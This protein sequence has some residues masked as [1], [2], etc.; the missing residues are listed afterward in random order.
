MSCH[1]LSLYLLAN[2]SIAGIS[3]GVLLES[4]SRS[5]RKSRLGCDQCSISID[6]ISLEA[7][8]PSGCYVILLADLSLSENAEVRRQCERAAVEVEERW[9]R[10]G[11]DEF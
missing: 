3:G 10:Q 11:L 7:G 1:S 2:F 5:V 6:N 4:L 9:M 8:K